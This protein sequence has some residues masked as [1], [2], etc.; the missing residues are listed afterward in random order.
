MNFGLQKKTF[1]APLLW[2]K[3]ETCSIIT[4]ALRLKKKKSAPTKTTRFVVVVFVSLY[5]SLTLKQKV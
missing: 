1:P 5:L 2:I 3:I 4:R